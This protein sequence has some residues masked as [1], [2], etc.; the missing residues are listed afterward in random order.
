MANRQQI[1]EHLDNLLD[2]R[3]IQDTSR[4]GLQVEGAREVEKVGLAVDAS[5]AAYRKAVEAGCQMLIVHHGLIWTGLTHVT[6]LVHRH[7]RYLFDHDLNLYA[8]HLPLDLHPRLG[9]NARLAAILG[10]TGLVPSFE[11][12]GVKLGFR[13]RLKR[14][15]VNTE[16]VSRLVSAIGGSPIV[17]P[18]GNTRNRTVGVE[19]GGGAG[20]LPQAIDLGL[21][22]YITGEPAHRNHHQAAEAGI[23]VIYAGHYETETVG[24]K[25]LGRHLERRFRV[26]TV[27]LDVPTRV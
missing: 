20:E 22:C 15:L 6:G 1:V 2:T 11:Y 21:D 17:L 7:I 4:N 27:F 10:L 19:S 13:G 3:G 9:N 16:I 23:N 14:P 24:V 8:A 5:L 26:K 18:F 12:H 25:A